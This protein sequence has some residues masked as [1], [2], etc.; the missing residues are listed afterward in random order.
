VREV[1]PKT[2]YTITARN[3]RG[4]APTTIQF[5]TVQDYRPVPLEQWTTDMVQVWLKEVLMF[6][7]IDLLE[8]L[9]MNGKVL[10]TCQSSNMEPLAS[11]RLTATVKVLFAKTVKELTREQLESMDRP[12]MTS[13]LP[14]VDLIQ[15]EVKT[16]ALIKTTYANV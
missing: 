8:F 16:I 4:D 11:K 6:S 14:S 2:A 1:C 9:G 3:K 15:E 5:A 10:A 7:D 12:L 13:E